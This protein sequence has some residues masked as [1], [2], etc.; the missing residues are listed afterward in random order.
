MR[1]QKGV[2]SSLGHSATLSTAPTDKHDT[3][4]QEQQRWVAYNSPADRNAL[5]ALIPAA[6][7]Q[8]YQ[9][10]APC[11]RGPSKH[12]TQISSSQYQGSSPG[13]IEADDLKLATRVPIGRQFLAV[14]E[15]RSAGWS[16]TGR[17]EEGYKSTLEGG[18]CSDG[19]G[20]Q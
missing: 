8:K 14:D 15:T 19:W 1:R 3:F 10:Q 4:M 12:S 17:R 18:R 2:S 13:R 7:Q 20:A 6:L 9:L 5:A 11:C 16:K